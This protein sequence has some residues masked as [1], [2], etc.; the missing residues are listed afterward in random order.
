MRDRSLESRHPAFVVGREMHVSGQAG[1]NHVDIF[2][3]HARRDDEAIMPGYEIHERSARANH[4]ARGVNAQVSDHTVLGRP[5]LRSRELILGCLYSLAQLK[6]LALR[7]AQRLRDLVLAIVLQFE[8]RLLRFAYDLRCARNL[9]RD[10]TPPP[11]DIRHFPFK[12]QESGAAL[13]ALVDQNGDRGY[14][15]AN[16]PGP[17]TRGGFLRLEALDLLL[18]LQH[19]LPDHGCL[20][21]ENLSTR[22]DD[23]L[24][25]RED[26]G[27]RRV[28]L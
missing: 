3:S 7:V 11:I 20:R 13:I 1:M 16:D 12:A 28:P 24:L 15:L 25:S 4:A 17:L 27:N 26:R 6:N 18:D 10:V 14:L 19:F 5:N 23:A 21:L 9:C 22:F 2:G 8:E